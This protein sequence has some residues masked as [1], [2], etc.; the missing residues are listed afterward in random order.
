MLVRDY[1]PSARRDS[2]LVRQKR[3]SVFRWQKVEVIGIALG[4]E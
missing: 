3:E 2:W 4:V 1:A